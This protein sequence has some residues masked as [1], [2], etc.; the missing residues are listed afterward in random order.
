[1]NL[2][3]MKEHIFGVGV[4]CPGP[5]DIDSGR[6]LDTPNLK[7]FA[8]FNTNLDDNKIGYA[9]FNNNTRVQLHNKN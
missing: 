9:L 4:S 5:L 2:E 1:M 8:N 7:Q 6:I 3:I